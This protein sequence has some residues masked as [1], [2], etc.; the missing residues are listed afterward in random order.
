MMGDDGNDTLSGGRGKDVLI[1][2]FENL[3]GGRKFAVLK[4][5]ARRWL[6]SPSKRFVVAGIA[7][8]PSRAASFP[9]AFRSIVR[10]VDRLYLYLDGHSEVPEPA[11]NDPRVVPILWSEVPGLARVPRNDSR[12]G[13]L[14]IPKR[15]RRHCLSA[16]LRGEIARRTPSPGPTCSRR[17]SRFDSSSAAQELSTESDGPLFRLSIGSGKGRRCARIR[18]GDVR[19]G[20]FE[21]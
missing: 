12:A 1:G 4:A 13:T 15:G 7:T 17:L 14:F 10:Q 11:R 3:C 8:S 18:N 2:G 6:R 19:H 20:G 16:G 5:V 9:T 21:L